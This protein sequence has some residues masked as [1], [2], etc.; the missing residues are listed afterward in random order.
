MYLVYQ[1]PSYTA[2][3]TVATSIIEKKKHG[4][5]LPLQGV[6]PISGWGSMKTRQ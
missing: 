4:T 6:M 3:S 2:F 5:I 1:K